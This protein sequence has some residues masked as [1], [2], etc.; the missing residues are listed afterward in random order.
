MLNSLL[1]WLILRSWNAD[2]KFP[3]SSATSYH[4][5]WRH[6]LEDGASYGYCRKNHSTDSNL[7]SKFCSTLKYSLSFRNVPVHSHL[8]SYIA[9][10][11]ERNVIYYLRWRRKQARYD[12]HVAHVK[13]PREL[14]NT[15]SYVFVYACLLKF[16]KEREKNW[17]NIQKYIIRRFFSVSTTVLSARY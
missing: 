9:R 11:Q 14:M 13:K 15:S 7:S 1:T 10:Y 3:Q 4:T 6:V 17:D 2:S 5:K 16:K 12:F 8:I